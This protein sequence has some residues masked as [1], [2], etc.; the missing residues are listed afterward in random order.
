[1]NYYN[2]I[3]EVSLEKLVDL[4]KDQKIEWQKLLEIPNQ[5]LIKKI[6]SLTMEQIIKSNFSK[7]INMS[8]VNYF[9]DF[10]ENEYMDNLVVNYL[11]DCGLNNQ[12]LLY[13]SSEKVIL[14]FLSI[15]PSEE[16]QLLKKIKYSPINIGLIKNKNI[17]E[18]AN[19]INNQDFHYSALSMVLKGKSKAPLNTLIDEKYYQSD[20]ILKLL[21]NFFP[22]DIPFSQE[23]VLKIL[24]KNREAFFDLPIENQIDFRVLKYTTGNILYSEHD[25]DYDRTDQNN[26]SKSRIP[27]SLLN[28]INEDEN[29]LCVS[30]FFLDA[31]KKNINHP[32]IQ[33]IISNPK[34]TK[35]F[36]R[37]K[38]LLDDK[39]Q[40]LFPVY[41]LNNIP[42]EK[43]NEITYK[44]INRQD[45]S[46]LLKI[47]LNT[48]NKNVL[49][50][51]FL[52]VLEKNIKLSKEFSFTEKEVFVKN[53]FETILNNDNNAI[54]SLDTLL[55]LIIDIN[56]KD[57]EKM[58]LIVKRNKKL[59]S[60]I[61]NRLNPDEK[62]SYIEFSSE[63]EKVIK[64]KRIR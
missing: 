19:I 42:V 57:F 59:E 29:G 41:T 58:Y 64:Y 10:Y 63:K 54:K 1:M 31:N 32:N 37:Y 53:S 40:S 25:A 55:N 52:C 2:I 11:K 51:A 34:Y 61:D 26:I 12:K 7:S 4:L 33:K 43:Y 48:N 16:E 36:E 47:M 6:N 14:K 3:N 15:F 45:K 46:V 38:D 5:K 44:E 13:E 17:V 28:Y 49:L 20:E 21:N 24:S 27:N 62:L 50:N 56:S 30:L 39:Y 23:C 18:L 9:I 60:I 8:V 35:K 22:R